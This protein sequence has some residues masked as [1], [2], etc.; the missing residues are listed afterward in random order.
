MWKILVGVAVVVVIAWFV[1]KRKK[2]A[3]EQ[4]FTVPPP[5]PSTTITPPFRAP[6]EW[7][8]S[9]VQTPPVRGRVFST[10]KNDLV[11][12]RTLQHGVYWEEW[13]LR[14]V[15]EFYVPGTDM[16]DLGGN[17]GTTALLMEEVLS[18][19]CQVHVFEPIY[20]ELLR[21]T[22]DANGIA[23]DRVVLYEVGVGNA[24]TSVQVDIDPW[25]SVKNFGAT[26]LQSVTGAAM[27]ASAGA[28][29]I[30]IVKLDDFLKPKRRVSVV[31]IDVE[32][33]EEQVLEGMSRL[34]EKDRPVILMEVWSHK[35]DA[36][37]AS[38]IGKHIARL[39]DIRGIPEGQDDFL[40]VPKK[41]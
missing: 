4:P 9:V 20:H 11:V 1:W 2:T 13:M 38:D 3:V 33:M 10:L 41:N 36:F 28:S 12:G 14:Y 8:A 40:L 30:P 18:P 25:D 26:L 35:K 31:K 22:L 19:G 34:I 7:F 39:Y 21:Q 32:G 27:A 29:S 15:K 17:M 24:N 37:F 23:R 5:S 16:M 6:K